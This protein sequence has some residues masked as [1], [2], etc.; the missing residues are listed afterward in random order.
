MRYREQEG[1]EQFDWNEH[2]HRLVRAIEVI[3]GDRQGRAA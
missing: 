1:V 3:A 2:V